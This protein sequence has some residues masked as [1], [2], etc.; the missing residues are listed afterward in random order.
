M[1]IA[2]MGFFVILI[3]AS[4]LASGPTVPFAASGPILTIN[5]GD[6]DAAGSSGRFVVKNRTVTGMFYGSIGGTQG[7]S[8]VITYGSNVP[9]A[10][11]SGQ[12]HARLIAGSHEAAVV[13]ESSIG[14]TPVPCAIPDG[15]TCIATP[16]G[17]FIPGLLLDGKATF[18]S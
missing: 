11:Q 14:V 6:V 10:T 3:P 4:A 17:N 5:D 1:S 2:T 9:I 15:A 7:V 12:I 18:I 8:F 13:L 16:T